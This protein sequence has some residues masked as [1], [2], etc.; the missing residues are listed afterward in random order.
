[1]L[2]YNRIDVSEVIDFTKT[3]APKACILCRFWYFYDKRFTFRPTVYNDCLDTLCF[4][5]KN[6]AILNIHGFD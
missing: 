3:S 6:I 5:I 2:Y 1:M 4:D